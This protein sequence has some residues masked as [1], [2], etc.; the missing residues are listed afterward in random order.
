MPQTR[1]PEVAGGEKDTQ[2]QSNE[3]EVAAAP[4][5]EQQEQQQELGEVQ[6]DDSPIVNPAPSYADEDEEFL[7]GQTDL[8]DE[9]VSTSSSLRPVPSKNVYRY[10]SVLAKAAED[11]DAPAELHAFI[12]ILQES[13]SASDL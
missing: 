13:L 4:A 3:M 1:N 12:R 10:L 6:F 5:K 9:P 8:P 11:P 2:Q 7:F